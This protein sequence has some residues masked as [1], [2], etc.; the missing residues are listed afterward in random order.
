MGYF[1]R[2]RKTGWSLT[3][4]YYQDGQCCGPTVPPEEYTKYTFSSLMTVD[5]AKAHAKQ[6]NRQNRKDQW[7]KKREK[8]LSRIK[9]EDV[10]EVAHLPMH[11]C[12]T[13]K[14]E[15]ESLPD[16]KRLRSIWRAARKLIKQVN[17]PSQEWRRRSQAIYNY[18]ERAHLSKDYAKKIIRVMNLWGEFYSAKT[19]QPYSHLKAP[20]GFAAGRIVHSYNKYR[21][22]NKASDGL[23]P[24]T[25]AYARRSLEQ[26]HFNWL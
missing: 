24:E 9:I 14:I 5:E 12:Q 21:Q 19:G 4:T 25:L 26:D 1:V 8:I 2:T 18:F 11:L 7:S 17:I 16:P 23:T 10:E 3:R 6:L 15:L 13:F 22:Q 20:T